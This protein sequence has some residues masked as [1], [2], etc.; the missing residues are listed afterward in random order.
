M[1]D[2][3]NH[4]DVL[5]GVKQAQDADKDQ[6][7]HSRECDLFLNKRD[8]QWEPDIA[9]QFRRNGRPRYTFDLCNPVIN[10]LSGAIRMANFGI[11]VRPAN[12]QADEDRADVL[13]GMIRNIESISGAQNI[14]N[15]AATSMVGTGFDAWMITQEYSDSESFDQDL[16]IRPINSAI[17]TVYWDTNSMRQDHSDAMWGTKL[18]AMSKNA[19]KERWPDGSGQSV[20][21]DRSQSGY[22]D[23]ADQVIVGEFY[24]IEERPVTLVQMSDG[25]VYR[26]DDLEKIQD[27][28]EQ[29]GITEMR[30]RK[31]MKRVV[32][33]RH[34]DGADWLN[35]A[36]ETV[37]NW[38]PLIPLYGYFRVS[39]NKITFRGE[40][41]KLLDQ[42]RVHNYAHSAEVLQTAL[43]PIDKIFITPEQA[44]DHEPQLERMNQSSDS[45][46]YYNHVEDQPNP[47]RMGT[48]QT[49]PNLAVIANSTRQAIIQSS[50][51]FAASMGD[52]PS[53]QSGVAI[54]QLQERGDVS[55]VH[56]FD[57][58]EVALTH[59][60]KILVDAIPKVYDATRRVRILGEDG[61][62]SQVDLNKAVLEDG[63]TKIINDLSTGRYDVT[64]DIGK[65]FKSRQQESIASILE[66]ASIDPTVVEMG[67]DILLN[68]A[69]GPSLDLIA[70]RKRLQLMN[71]GL[72]PEDQWTDEE[73][74]AM[75]EA[76]A[77]A[78][79]QPQQPSMEEIGLQIQQ[80]D[81]QA[82]LLSA[83]N[84]QQ[85]LMADT[86]LKQQDQEIKA[87]QG[88]QKFELEI[89]KMQQ[90]M[91]LAMEENQRANQ[92]LAM[93][94]AKSVEEMQK[95]Q[96]E[97]MKLIKES[98]GA[99]AII[100]PSAA[101][102][103]EET[104]QNLAEGE[105]A[106]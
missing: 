78:A 79:Q 104:A 18:T 86:Q 21:E 43:S 83:Q 65:S 64:M 14:Y 4:T 94:M 29:S 27:R 8:G 44:A 62:P 47:Y 49:N 88:Q 73:R 37:F 23:K 90:S 75:Q 6:R 45:V 93:S 101:I 19:Y 39:D 56:Y 105:A 57:A 100:S 103:Y 13:A 72:I 16:Y 34:Y 10:T 67:S 74:Q 24:W 52:N 96:A 77:L 106:Q 22:Y 68:N 20:A 7:E 31:R 61:V 2:F 5:N 42:Q 80:M 97:T 58:M 25:S 53:L 1:I 12:D 32:K 85:K 38:I 33:V 36:Q 82:K 71:S 76:Q 15:N 28:L 35:E 11:K 40:T 50:G 46:Q 51:V 60:A 102:A 30:R 66:M 92:E 41:E 70:Q 3:S 48:A 17:D 59:T 99:Q 84:D 81:A 89:A 95:T 91:A 9:Q 63:S 98:T 69:N 26:E 87:V 55:M 54:E